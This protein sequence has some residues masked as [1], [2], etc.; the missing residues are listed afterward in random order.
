MIRTNDDSIEKYVDVA[1]L[2]YIL[3]AGVSAKTSYSK[4]LIAFASH[5]PRSQLTID[6]AVV[7]LLYH[8]L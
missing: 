7:I 3:I 2:K 5:I 1:V 8:S 6:E 4:G